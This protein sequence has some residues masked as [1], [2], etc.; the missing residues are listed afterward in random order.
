MRMKRVKWKGF[1]PLV[2]P[3][4]WLTAQVYELFPGYLYK[5]GN[6]QCR[7]RLGK[8]CT[9]HTSTSRWHIPPFFSLVANRS[10]LSASDAYSV[11]LTA[12]SIGTS[13][14]A[15]VASSRMRLRSDPSAFILEYFARL[16][17]LWWSAWRKCVGRRQLGINCCKSKEWKWVNEECIDCRRRCRFPLLYLPYIDLLLGLLGKEELWLLSSFPYIYSWP[18]GVIRL[19][20]TAYAFN[21]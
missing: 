11:C 1:I 3:L 8:D 10:C 7:L 5:S 9:V 15:A 4:G 14:P 18:G 13:V 12:A 21:K 6:D 19:R 2:G 16:L 20:P 17:V